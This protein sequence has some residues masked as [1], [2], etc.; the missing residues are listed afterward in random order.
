MTPQT[1]QQTNYNSLDIQE[2]LENIV[3]KV[4]IFRILLFII[5]SVP[6]TFIN[7][8]NINFKNLLEFI[9]SQKQILSFIVSGL[10]FN[11]IILISWRFFQNII[12]F[13]RLQ[14]ITDTILGIYFMWITG[15]ISS[16]GSFLLM[17]ILFLYG[18]LL[19]FK[20][21]L[22]NYLV[23]TITLI[24]MTTLQIKNPNVYL[25]KN[26]D[27]KQAIYFMILQFSGL[28]LV[29]LLVK[30]G[31]SKENILLREIAKQKQHFY[32]SEIIKTKVFDWISSGIIVID[33]NG[34]IKSINKEASRLLNLN[35]QDVLGKDLKNVSQIFHQLWTNWDKRS[36]KRHDIHVGS[37]IIGVSLSPIPEHQGALIIFTDITRI[38]ELEQKIAQMERLSLI[39]ELSAGL[40]HEIKNPLSGIKGALQLIGS[41]KVNDDQKQRLTKIIMRD[42]GRLDKLLKDFLY[43]AKPKQP[44]KNK[45]ILEDFLK[46]LISTIKITYPELKIYITPSV[47]GKHL[48]WDEDQLKQVLLNLIINSIEAMNESKE[49]KLVLG[50]G[51]DR[52]NRKFIFV[53]DVGCGIDETH[54]DQLFY[55]FF[56]TKSDG[57]G[58][59]LAIA[60]RL[61]SENDSWIEIKNRKTMGVLAKIYLSNKGE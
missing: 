20:T 18:R 54:K 37:K 40:A 13:F 4:C 39:G 28:S 9:F 61:C 55:P 5:L 32:E 29:L 43:F 30:M 49:K 59:G 38:K 19:G 52:D 34:T 56:T 10:F 33:K 60:Q 15:G 50:Y 35:L 14:L 53:Q 31:Q 12:F 8:E 16:N 24:I 58:L 41:S 48:Y 3:V 2:F 17:G 7:L 51:R 57:T 44:E 26:L 23:I 25:L 45:I 36:P 21:S 11:L 27:P 22:Y 47:Y 1:A 6:L 46:K 42:I